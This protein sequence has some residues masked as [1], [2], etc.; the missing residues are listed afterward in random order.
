MGP[1]D[2]DPKE[3]ACDFDAGRHAIRG[4]ILMVFSIIVS[5]CFIAWMLYQCGL[6]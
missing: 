2:E 6:L 5:L 1:Y 4:C 3:D